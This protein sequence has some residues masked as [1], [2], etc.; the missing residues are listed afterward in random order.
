L[1]GRLQSG[2][3]LKPYM[4]PGFLQHLGVKYSSLKTLNPPSLI[5]WILTGQCNLSCSHCYASRF[6]SLRSLT[7]S[8]AAKILREAWKFGVSSVSFTGGEP[9]LY[10][11]IFSLLDEASAMSMSVSL[12]SNGSTLTRDTVRKIAKHDV[13]LYLSVD[14]G[15]ETHE[16]LR[17]KGT[18]K[19]VVEAAENLRREDVPYSTVTVLTRETLK[20]LGSAVEF[21]RRFDAE[22]ACVIPVM[23]TGEASSLM[24]PSPSETTSAILGFTE[25]AYQAGVLAEV[26]CAPFMRLY[27]KPKQALVFQCRGSSVADLDSE[28]KLLL[29]DVLDFRLA[30]A[31]KTGFAEAWKN[32]LNHPLYR[33]LE[34]PPQSEV[35]LKCPI[36]NQCMGGCYAR[37]LL[38]SRELRQPDPLCPKISQAQPSKP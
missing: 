10:Q 22:E 28:G 27:V 18:W 14:G 24:L 7:T 34:K 1:L 9:L 29:C 30:D 38:L 20:V 3:R 6:R 21:A 4:P 33:S 36:F 15:K 19:Y 17:G 31:L 16:K 25:A 12:V 23:P 8:Q 26:W 32:Y 13:H 2:V 35:C 11:G 37:A 5:V